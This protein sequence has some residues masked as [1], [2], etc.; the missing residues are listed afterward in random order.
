MGEVIYPKIRV[1]LYKTTSKILK[2]L[3]KMESHKNIFKA[4]QIRKNLSQIFIPACN[5]LFKIE[6]ILDK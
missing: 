5:F 4:S 6:A 3:P 2:I 1:R